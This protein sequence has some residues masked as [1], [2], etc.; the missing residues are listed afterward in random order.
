M[1]SIIN[2]FPWNINNSIKKT[3]I[4]HDLLTTGYNRTATQIRFDNKCKY[5]E[6]MTMTNMSK[7]MHI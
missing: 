2:I 4:P 7:Y 5:K 6:Q 3:D 1:S